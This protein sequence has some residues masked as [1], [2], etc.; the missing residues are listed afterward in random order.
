M[1]KSEIALIGN[2]T[3]PDYLQGRVLLRKV[4]QCMMKYLEWSAVLP[5]VSVR[6]DFHALEPGCQPSGTKDTFSVD[7]VESMVQGEFEHV[8]FIVHFI[9]IVIYISSTSSSI[10]SWRVGTSALEDPSL[11]LFQPVPSQ[12]QGCHDSSSTPYLNSAQL[13]ELWNPLP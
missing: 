1:A 11:A 7:T 12:K 8:T 5:L 9:S 3:F 4:H 6:A 13:S 2:C 10:R